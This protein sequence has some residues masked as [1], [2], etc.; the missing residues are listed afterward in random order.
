VI[1]AADDAGHAEFTE[2]LCTAVAGASLEPAQVEL[3]LILSSSR[4]RIA[5]VAWS[6]CLADLSEAGPRVLVAAGSD[7]RPAALQAG[8]GGCR[9]RLYAVLA[10]ALD[11]QPLRP[12]HRGTWLGR[13]EYTLDTDLGDVG[14]TLIPLTDEI[15]AE[16]KLHENTL[17]FVVA[18]Q[19]T[20]PEVEAND[21]LSVYVDEDVLARLASETNSRGARSFQQQLFLDAM[22]TVVYRGARELRSDDAPGSFLEGQASL[23]GRLIGRVATVEHH[24]DDQLAQSYW[25]VARE[26]PGRLVALIEGWLPSFKKSLIDSLKDGDQ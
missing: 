7:D 20:N 3:V 13:T 25:I 22:T 9:A 17:R 1:L 10:E 24:V 14:F 6:K 5:D 11:A 4:L 12:S 18:E 15:R 2:R 16:H 21:V 19:V 8:V 23:L 26:E